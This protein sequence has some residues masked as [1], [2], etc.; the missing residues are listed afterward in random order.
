[1]ISL[2]S[3]SDVTSGVAAVIAITALLAINDQFL[4]ST[5]LKMYLLGFERWRTNS[6]FLPGATGDFARSLGVSEYPGGLLFNVP[7]LLATAVPDSATVITY[8]AFISLSL[9]SVVVVLAHRLQLSP[10][11]RQI[12][13]FLM[14]LALFIP[15]PQMLNSVGRYDP[16]F[17]WAITSVTATVLIVS[18]A[19]RLNDW[20]LILLSLIGGMFTFWSNIQFYP[21][22]LPMLLVGLLALVWRVRRMPIL[23]RVVK[24]SVASLVPAL[25]SGPIFLGTYLFSVWRIP[26]EAVAENVDVPMTLLRFVGFALPFPG[27]SK[28][29]P[30]VTETSGLVLRV[31]ALVG[32]LTAAS[33]SRRQG[34]SVIAGVS[35]FAVILQV[36]YSA[37]Y[38]LGVR[39]FGLEIGLDPTYVQVFAYPVWI[40]LLLNF[41]FS[42]LSALRLG[43]ILQSP[44]I[45]LIFI[46]LWLGQWTVR[47]FDT[48]TQASEYPVLISQ[49][50]RMLK[51]LTDADQQS[52]LLTRTIIIQSQF[53]EQRQPEGYRIR[54]SSDFSETLL[55]E[56][57]ALRVPVLNAY[58]HT[59][60][61]VTF[62]MTNDLFGDGRP[63]WRQFSLF[64]KPNLDAMPGL[65][66]RY[67]LS[68]EPIFDPRVELLLVEPFK[69][70][71]TYPTSS[72]VFLYQLSTLSRDDASSVQYELRGSTLRV[73][74][75]LSSES[76]LLL[77]IEF[78]KCL[79]ITNSI[80]GES[81]TISRDD[82][83]LVR[84]GAAGKLDITLTYSNSMFQFKNCRIRDF[85]HFR[86]T[87]YSR[88]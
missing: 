84:I 66:I 57:T 16:S 71:G 63:S 68:E 29:L 49:A 36:V 44:L 56:L 74:G 38:S 25:L 4:I 46:C 70:S 85:L 55:M 12:A 14:P 73:V 32:I 5:D 35:F 6:Q 88:T 75:L 50:S 13:G 37:A 67:I 81:V 15:G 53:P 59:I 78:S 82:R 47:N 39:F 30:S 18:Y 31:V 65:G 19:H 77:P 27:L 60:S 17:L 28:Y 54:R 83:G 8:G 42:R 26:D 51:S 72:T 34:K 10:I 64:D 2:K 79:Q 69:I 87:Q 52:G 22:V 24:A 86:T 7:W 76:S 62:S 41:V 11:V 9:Y 40:L 23:P 48:R 1:M 20:A 3:R 80:P 33:V 58:T 43:S 21:V 61:P 45:P